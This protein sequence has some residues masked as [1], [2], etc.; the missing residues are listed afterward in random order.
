MAQSK[1]KSEN[2]DLPI[3]PDVRLVPLPFYDV[4]AT[5][6]QPTSLMPLLTNNSSV[7]KFSLTPL[8]INLLNQNRVI[9]NGIVDYQVQV[10]LRLCLSETTSEQKDLYPLDLCVR[11][12]DKE[13]PLP[14]K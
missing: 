3:L 13:C 5:L 10:Q 12:N 11:V 14:V 6:L 1:Q 7:V 4:E 9:V 2:S 8:Q